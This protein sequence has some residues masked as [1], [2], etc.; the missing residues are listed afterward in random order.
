MSKILL[1]AASLA[2]AVLPAWAGDEKSVDEA[3]K[4]FRKDMANPSASA[5]AS[6]ATEL[7]ATKSEKTAATLGSLLVQ[8]AAEV[9]KAAA[10]G[11][12]GFSDYKKKAVGILL[13]ALGVNQSMPPVMEAIF[14]ALG[15]LDDDSALPTIHGYFENKDGVIASAALM[16]AADIRNVASVDL[17]IDLMKKYEKIETAA[18]NG[19]GGG[20][21]YAGYNVPGGGDDPKLKL[22]KDVLPA[23]VKAMQKIS[24]DKWATVKEWEIWWSK[25]KATFKTDSK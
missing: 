18:K 15:K 1:M 2:A 8:D 23:T 11:L 5:R 22:A 9:R 25:H 20:A 19:G 13:A 21:G 12:G 24:G 3:L 4:K 6:A 7:A 16:A 17:I 10:A 14:Q